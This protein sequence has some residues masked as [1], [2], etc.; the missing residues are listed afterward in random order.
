MTTIKN[1]ISQNESNQTSNN[2]RAIIINIDDLGLSN[3]VNDA[4]LHLAERGRIGASSYM[5]GGNITDSDIR[6]LTELNV[7]IGLHFDLTGIFPSV[8]RGS[9]KSIII[10]SY[11]RTLDSAQVVDVIN[12]QLDNFEDRFGRAPVFIDGHQHIHQFPIIR[13]HLISELSARY[14]KTSQTNISA[15][16]TTPLINDI[17]SWVIYALGGKAWRNLC[18][19]NDMLTNDCFG[20]VYGFDASAQELAIL[21]ENWLRKA[22]RT[23][24]LSPALHTPSL[25]IEP[26]GTYA[27]YGS[28]TPAIHS[29]PLSLPTNLTTTL[30]MCHPAIPN[31][32][33]QDDIKQAREHEYE[34]LMSHQ[35][36]ELLLKY[37]VRLL[38][39]SE[40]VRQAKIDCKLLCQANK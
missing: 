33:W 15:R 2:A 36:E 29:V 37:D 38:R 1:N 17:K 19:E 12:K 21:W 10:A 24:D 5:A 28:T 34:W 35:F 11:L 40:C 25:P 30:I 31:G 39:W 3:A 27:Q 7:D 4:V 8:L 13:Q 23:V 9:L 6:T 26:L 14:G 18:K 32:S 20:G 22:P 16:V